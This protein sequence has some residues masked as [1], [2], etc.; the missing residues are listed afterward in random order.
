MN[1][2]GYITSP[3]KYENILKH[4]ADYIDTYSIQSLSISIVI[5]EV[6]LKTKNLPFW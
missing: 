1:V 2:N 4:F 5:S 6:D 3:V